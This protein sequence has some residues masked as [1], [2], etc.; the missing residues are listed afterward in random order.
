MCGRVFPVYNALYCDDECTIKIL[1]Q[2]YKLIFILSFSR[3]PLSSERR[4]CSRIT[5]NAKTIQM[6]TSATFSTKNDWVERARSWTPMRTVRAAIPSQ[7]Q[8]SVWHAHFE[9]NIQGPQTTTVAYH[10]KGGSGKE[11]ELVFIPQKVADRLKEYIKDKDI[12]PYQRIFPITYNAARVMVN[13]AGKLVRIYLR[14]HDLRRFC[15]TYASRAGTPIRQPIISY[16]E[17]S[18]S[19]KADMKMNWDI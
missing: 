14:P 19:I 15:A 3:Y 12:E 7:H 13:K 5:T 1:V 8:K 2:M 17:G 4:R 9:K 6:K 18:K 16:L 10:R 11:S